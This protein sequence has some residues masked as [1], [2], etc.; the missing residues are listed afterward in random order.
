MIDTSA[1][2]AILLHEPE[3]APLARAIAAAPRRLLSALSLLEAGI[4]IEAKKG[5]E[6]A[7]QL[8]LLIHRAEIEVVAMNG[9]QAELARTAWRR[10]GKGRH[11][12]RLNLGDCCAYALSRYSG[13]ALLFKGEDFAHTDVAV[14]AWEGFDGNC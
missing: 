11:P 8:D 3:G 4:V 12:A 1:L 14:V 5:E 6:G 7:R 13:E 9:E 2:I 10:Y